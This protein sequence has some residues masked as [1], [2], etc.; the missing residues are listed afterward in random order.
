MVDVT[1]DRIDPAA[2]IAAI[3]R[4]VVDSGCSRSRHL[5]RM[6]PLQATCFASL[7]DLEVT[8]KPLIEKHFGSA[9]DGDFAMLAMDGAGEAQ[10]TTP[11]S[12]ASCYM[13]W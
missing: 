8:A 3:M 12:I 5:I 9:A 13:R 2:V 1:D 4:D 10:D 6:M 7:E 11:M